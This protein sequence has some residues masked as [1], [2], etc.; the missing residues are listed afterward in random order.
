MVIALSEYKTGREKMVHQK[1]RVCFIVVIGM[2]FTLG[3]SGMGIAA[4]SH[5]QVGYGADA[6]TKLEVSVF[7][8]DK[9]PIE[10]AFVTID[11]PGAFETT[12]RTEKTGVFTAM[13][14]CKTDKA[15]SI[16]H[17]VVVTH[18]KYKTVNTTFTTT[19]GK[20]NEVQKLTIQLEPK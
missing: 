2:A 10:N 9:K 7:T 8:K 4:S 18:D 19:E 12:Y 14:A 15:K 11:S 16:T 20:C 6:K 1:T 13:I 3:V 5:T 17:K